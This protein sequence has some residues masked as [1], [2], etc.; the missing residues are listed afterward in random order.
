M[1]EFKCTVKDLFRRPLMI[2]KAVRQLADNGY[3]EYAVI[4]ARIRDELCKAMEYASANM[5]DYE[6]LM[7]VTY[8]QSHSSEQTIADKTF[9]T[10]RTI[11][12]YVCKACKLIGDYY[13]EFCGIRF[14]EVDTR[15][16][17]CIAVAGTFWQKV[18]ALMSDCIENAC[19]VILCCNENK[20][21][22]YVCNYYGMGSKKVRRIVDEFESSAMVYDMPSETRSAV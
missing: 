22:N 1:V 12:R 6:Y 3:S 15:A 17:D 19:A 2:D 13:S 8:L 20:S 4:Y 10:H 21:V 16:V 11:R 5:K 9:Y 7:A 14:L 18:D